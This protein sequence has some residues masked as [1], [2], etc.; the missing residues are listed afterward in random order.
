MDK[1]ELDFIDEAF[2]FALANHRGQTDDTG[3]PYFSVHVKV[4]ADL[5]KLVTSD[6]EIIAAAY[7]HDTLEDTCTTREQIEAIFGPR[8]AGLVFEVTHTGT[9]E[10]GFKYPS[11]KSRDAMMIKFADRLNNI[12]RM[13]TWSEEE[14]QDYLDRSAF[15]TLGKGRQRRD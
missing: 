11:L 10:E 14:K 5:V 7:L 2:C 8:V 3:K 13:E 9:K 6:P 1:N 15:W 4:V 12:S